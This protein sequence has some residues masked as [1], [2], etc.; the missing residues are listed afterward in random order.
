MGGS[1]LA[2][3]AEELLSQVLRH[4]GPPILGKAEGWHSRSSK[5]VVTGMSKDVCEMVRTEVV[6]TQTL[7]DPISK[8]VRAQMGASLF[9]QARKFKF[10]PGGNLELMGGER[11]G[12]KTAVTRRLITAGLP[13]HLSCQLIHPLQGA[14]AGS[15]RGGR[16]ASGKCEG[17]KT[18]EGL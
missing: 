17:A 9:R 6:R 15:P 5:G 10:H 14:K 1:G 3:S 16:V 13:S 12:R 11:R 4:E 7:E 18:R 8:E 2:Q